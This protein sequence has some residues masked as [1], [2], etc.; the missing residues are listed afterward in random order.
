MAV[1]PSWN[2]R[3]VGRA[4]VD[5]AAARLGADGV[6]VLHV[7]TLGPAHPDPGYAGTRVFHQEVGFVPLDETQDPWPGQPCP[8]MAR[9]PGGTR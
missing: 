1:D 5:A 7:K 9:W 2:R 8:L 3:G 4:L 6:R